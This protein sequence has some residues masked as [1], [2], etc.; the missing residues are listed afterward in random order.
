MSQGLLQKAIDAYGLAV[1]SAQA[2][3]Q[4]AFLAAAQ[5]RG[6]VADWIVLDTIQQ[7]VDRAR[8]S[9]LVVVPPGPLPEGGEVTMSVAQLGLACGGPLLVVP[10]HVAEASIGSRVLICWNGSRESARAWRDAW[11]FI[12]AAD[13]LA[14][15]AVR[16]RPDF[17]DDAA[18]RFRLSRWDRKVDVLSEAAADELAP[19]VLRGHARDWGS[20]LLVMGLYGRP[21]MSEQVLGGVSHELLADPPC[22]LLISH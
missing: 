20:D 12:L 6:V 21:R 7:L 11:P 1:D 9:D 19:E 22:P 5:G 13:H 8:L 4:L 10:D 18:L 14:V 2:R 17:D 15:A 16:P 3:A